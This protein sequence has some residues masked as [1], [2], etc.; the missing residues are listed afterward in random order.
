MLF[1]LFIDSLL[2]FYFTHYFSVLFFYRLCLRLFHSSLLFY[3]IEF[4]ILIFLF[5]FPSKS[6]FLSVQ[7]FLSIYTYLYIHLRFFFSH[8]FLRWISI[9]LLSSRLPFP[10]E[11][12]YTPAYIISASFFIIC[13]FF[14]WFFP[15][16][17]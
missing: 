2:L 7:F 5:F 17:V 8:L 14:S 12:L 15:F 1:Y 13:F 3:L 10:G 6:C 4:F 16:R 9:T 11:W